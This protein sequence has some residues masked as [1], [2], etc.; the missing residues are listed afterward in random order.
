MIRLSIAGQVVELNKRHFLTLIGNIAGGYYPIAEAYAGNHLNGLADWRD[1]L[2]RTMELVGW[3]TSVET[4]ETQI[5]D[6]ELRGAFRSFREHLQELIR[7]DEQI[8]EWLAGF[9]GLS[10]SEDVRDRR[11]LRRKLNRILAAQGPIWAIEEEYQAFVG[12]SQQEML[13]VREAKQ[14]MDRRLR[15]LLA[16]YDQ[17]ADSL[18]GG[19][20]CW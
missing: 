14:W 13:A 2:P 17:D 15:Q 12:R 1:A 10:F 18:P 20:S 4:V 11:R 19:R 16:H 8:V 9:V 6:V 7:L 5:D 3:E